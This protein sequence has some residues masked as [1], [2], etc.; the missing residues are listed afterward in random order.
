MEI[1]IDNIFKSKKKIRLNFTL[2]F[3]LS[4]QTILCPILFII[5]IN[6]NGEVIFLLLHIRDLVFI[7]F[8]PKVVSKES[9]CVLRNGM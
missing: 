1:F 4:M 9:Y 8:K 6:C 2:H 3:I 5:C 7:D